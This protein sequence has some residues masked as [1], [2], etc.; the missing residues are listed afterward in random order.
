MKYQFQVHTAD[1]NGWRVAVINTAQAKAL[2][3]HGKQATAGDYFGLYDIT[4]NF[5]KPTD[6]DKLT[7]FMYTLQAG[8]VSK[9]VVF[10]KSPEDA[11]ENFPAFM[12]LLD[13]LKAARHKDGAALVNAIENF[14]VLAEAK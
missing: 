5:V 6:D 11:V 7:D 8:D 14:E 10:G 9:L 1:F 4:H 3:L 2:G 13:A 12:A